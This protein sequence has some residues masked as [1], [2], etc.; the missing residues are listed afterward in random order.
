MMVQFKLR[1]NWIPRK[2]TSSKSDIIISLPTVRKCGRVRCRKVDI[3]DKELNLDASETG[4]GDLRA[5]LLSEDIT[6]NDTAHPTKATSHYIV[7][8]RRG[9]DGSMASPGKLVLS[10]SILTPPPPPSS[11]APEVKINT[12]VN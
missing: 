1:S 7:G 10:E 3:D 12:A 8:Y 2:M 6:I 11:R 9:H 5:A 4:A